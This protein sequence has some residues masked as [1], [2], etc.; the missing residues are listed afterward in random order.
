MNTKKPLR[1][2]KIHRTIIS[3]T[4]SLSVVAQE[5]AVADGSDGRGA[6]NADLADVVRTTLGPLMKRLDLPRIHVMAE[7]RRVLLH[8]DVAREADALAIE[9]A[10]EKLPDVE[11]VESHLHVGLVPGDTRPSEG[12]HAPS[13]MMTALLQAADSV[14]IQGAPGRA[15]AWGALSAI[16]EQVPAPE[17]Q[18]VF[19]HLP[20]DVCAFVR[21]RRHF[22]DEQLHWQT[23]LQLDAA[24]ALRG[25]ISLEE[26]A[27]LVPL[28]IR[29]LKKFV[30]EEAQ[31]IQAT[32]HTQLKQLWG[33]TEPEGA[34]PS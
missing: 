31:D 2:V 23:E 13:A 7:G 28:I 12:T 3:E 33:A 19:S 29:V 24:T 6:T 16:L 10:V 1:R 15:A 32:L 27:K 25:G 22:G 20:A 14:G 9:R 11:V 5:N 26:S 8:G 21:P 4:V 18:H 17:R 34:D 30:P